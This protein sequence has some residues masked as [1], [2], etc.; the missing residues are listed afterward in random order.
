MWAERE[1]GLSVISSLTLLVDD[2]PKVLPQLLEE[3]EGED[4]MWP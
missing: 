2:G 1:E 4:G 3:D